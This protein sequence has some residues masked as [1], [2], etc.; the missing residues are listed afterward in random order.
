MARFDGH[1]SGALG[2]SP[3]GFYCDPHP[4]GRSL[5]PASDSPNSSSSI[6]SSAYSTGM[7]ASACESAPGGAANKETM[8]SMVAMQAFH[9]GQASLMGNP[10]GLEQFDSNKQH[11]GRAV[12][13][14][15]VQN[16][17]QAE[18]QKRD[19]TGHL[20]SLGGPPAEP[21]DHNGAKLYQTNSVKLVEPQMGARHHPFHLQPDN[22]SGSSML[23]SS[24]QMIGGE[25]NTFLM[26]STPDRS[27]Q[28]GVTASYMS[29]A[30]KRRQHSPQTGNKPTSAGGYGSSQSAFNSSSDLCT[31]DGEAGTPFSR[32]PIQ[33]GSDMQQVATNLPPGLGGGPVGRP[34]VGAHGAAGPM[35]GTQILCKVCGDKAR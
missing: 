7:I 5:D 3:D 19:F 26:D 10:N 18:E 6:S 24:N 34:E 23:A 9:N 35:S 21:I 13:H 30:G 32:P 33:P 8:P 28:V 17:H 15:L 14:K 22:S 16:D 11:R 27:K 12:F 2:I 4:R 1:P 31:R 25:S 20:K 29:Q